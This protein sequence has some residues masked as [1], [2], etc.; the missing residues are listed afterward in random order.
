MAAIAAVLLAMPFA[1]PQAS[2]M[3]GITGGVVGVMAG[4][5]LAP[6]RAIGAVAGRLMAR[7]IEK[8]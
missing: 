2:W 1:Q 7:M 4:L 6:Y 8:P 5:G 3:A